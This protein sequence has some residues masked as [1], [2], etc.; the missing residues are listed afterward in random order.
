MT[1]AICIIASMI[2]GALLAVVVCSAAYRRVAALDDLKLR[3][4]RETASEQLFR[5]AHAIVMLLPSESAGLLLH[6]TAAHS[7]TNMA[8]LAT[9]RANALAEQL[10]NAARGGGGLEYARLAMAEAH[11]RGLLLPGYAEAGAARRE[12]A[13]SAD[14]FGDLLGGMA[15]HPAEPPADAAGPSMH[16]DFNW[17]DPACGTGNAPRH[18]CACGGA[19]S[20][21]RGHEDAPL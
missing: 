4:E 14:M 3:H 2:V 9:L 5:A 12:V 16:D 20:A 8:R 18:S 7:E 19:C 17:R 1:I 21:P 13:G 15:R 6:G 10:A 11:L